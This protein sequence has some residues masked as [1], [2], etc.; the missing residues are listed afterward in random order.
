LS[1]ESSA[2]FPLDLEHTPSAPLA[3]SQSAKLD[4]GMK[5]GIL[6][7]ENASRNGKKQQ[8][9]CIHGPHQASWRV[10]G[11]HKKYLNMLQFNS[12][13]IKLISSTFSIRTENLFIRNHSTT[14]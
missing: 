8:E 7:W 2:N 13:L 4:S 12:S 11:E 9:A 3:D 1:E 5:S 6:P 10:P 14:S